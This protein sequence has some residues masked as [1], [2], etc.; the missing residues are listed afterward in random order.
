[1]FGL[2]DVMKNVDLGDIL[3]KVGLSDSDKKEVT[4]QAAN[5]VKYR[6]TKETARGNKGIMENLFSQNKNSKDADV[7]AKK[8]EN[9][10]AFNLKK[11][12]NLEP[13]VIDQ[14]KS[15][16]MSKFLGGLAS[17]DQAKGDKEGKGMLDSFMDNDML[18]G[19][20]SKLGGFFK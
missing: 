5:A 7:V 10:L 11:N 15:A 2:E 12:T 18:D 6:T 9:D 20:K 8:M 4:N 16:V 17:T 1:M 19:F 14:V 3:Q 13:S